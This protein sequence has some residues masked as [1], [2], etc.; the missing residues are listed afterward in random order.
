MGRELDSKE[1]FR[2]LSHKFH[3]KGSGK[4]KTEKRMKKMLEQLALKKMDS[5]DTPLGSAALLREKQ[6]EANASYIV[7]SGGN[8]I[9]T[10]V[11][12]TLSKISKR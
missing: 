12:N 11:H 2:Q 5:D 3:G 10:D 8:R 1:A 4:M 9:P 7:L 6:K